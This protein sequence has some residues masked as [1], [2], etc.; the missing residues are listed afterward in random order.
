MILRQHG[1]F[2]ELFLLCG[3][4][5]C[6]FYRYRLSIKRVV[7]LWWC[8]GWIKRHA[9]SGRP[10]GRGVTEITIIGEPVR[11]PSGIRSGNDGNRVSFPSFRPTFVCHSRYL[12]LVRNRSTINIWSAAQK[13][14]VAALS[15]F[16]Y[17]A[18]Y[19]YCLCNNRKWM[20][21]VGEKKNRCVE[22]RREKRKGAERWEKKNIENNRG[23]L[24]TRGNKGNEC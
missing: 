2:A 14:Y 1:N 16:I 20:R 17:H 9:Y 24:R 3:L 7:F 4:Q 8:Q 18:R 6:R 19:F 21:R 23:N 15:C 10:A 5:S 12:R 11:I 22:R 13:D